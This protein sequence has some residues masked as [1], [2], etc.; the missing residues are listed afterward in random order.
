MQAHI[1]R[2]TQRLHQ[3]TLAGPDG[4]AEHLTRLTAEQSALFTAAGLAP[5]KRL[6]GM[7]PAA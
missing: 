6:T 7:T 5:P 4:T 1:R 3:V 2:Q